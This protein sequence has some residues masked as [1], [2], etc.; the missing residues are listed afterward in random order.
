MRTNLFDANLTNCRPHGAT[1]TDV[2]INDDTE[3]RSEDHREARKSRSKPNRFVR[4][5]DPQ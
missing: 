4:W 5:D 3:L 1:F 2:Q